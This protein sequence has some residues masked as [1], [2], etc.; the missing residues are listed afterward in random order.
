MSNKVAFTNL[1]VESMK[2]KLSK[3]DD[4]SDR[5]A[6]LTKL[7][8]DSSILNI[9]PTAFTTIQ[10]S[11]VNGTI[12]SESIMSIVQ[13]GKTKISTKF[14]NNA[15]DIITGIK[16]LRDSIEWADSKNTGDNEEGGLRLASATEE[17]A[18]GNTSTVVAGVGE[19]SNSQGTY[20]IKKTVT[21]SRS[22]FIGD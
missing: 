10:P 14:T 22:P 18:A 3:L 8:D 1:D 13:N 16:A 7:L 11:V 12:S 15:I 20:N 9:K 17:I 6:S 5:I 2:A 21:L 4:I 19:D